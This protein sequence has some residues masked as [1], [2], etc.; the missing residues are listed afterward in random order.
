MKILVD[1]DS[2]NKI[3]SIIEMGKE[4]Y[5]EVH[6]FFDYTHN[7]E[8]QEGVILHEVAQGVD[9]ADYSIITYCEKEDIVV[10]KDGGLAALV[11][12]KGAYAVH[13]NGMEF[14]DSNILS[15]LTSRHI[16]KRQRMK[17]GKY[18]KTRTEKTP[19]RYNFKKTM[20][21]II[22]RVLK[23]GDI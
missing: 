16:N 19:I 15:I 6:L 22:N 3:P 23:K 13:T 1:A 14:D 8:E 17:G 21:N 5:L 20:T 2:C 4:H 7:Y 10:T 18:F 11:L 9:S 12:A